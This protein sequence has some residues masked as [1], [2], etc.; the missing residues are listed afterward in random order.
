MITQ[1]LT[2]DFIIPDLHSSVLQFQQA[3]IFINSVLTNGFKK[4]QNSFT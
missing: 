2:P 3:T 4:Q 1:P